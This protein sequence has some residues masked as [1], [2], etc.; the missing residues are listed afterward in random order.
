LSHLCLG[1]PSGSFPRVSPP[2]PCMHLSSPP[3][4]PHVLSISVF[5]TWSPEE[6]PIVFGCKSVA[7]MRTKL[8]SVCCV[9]FFFRNC[10][11]CELEGRSQNWSFRCVALCGLFVTCL[12]YVICMA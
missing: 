3:Y 6:I 11:V 4:V 7:K 2:K 1:L 12:V 9:F 8:C 5:L 10:H